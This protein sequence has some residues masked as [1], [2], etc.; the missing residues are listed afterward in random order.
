MWKM[1]PALAEECGLP[2][3]LPA[4]ADGEKPD[5]DAIAAVKDALRCIKDAD[6]TDTACG[7]YLDELEAEREAEKEEMAADRQAAKEKAREVME[8]LK[9]VHYCLRNDVMPFLEEG[10][11]CSEAFSKP[12]D[13]SVGAGSGE[14]EFAVELIETLKWG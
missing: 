10:S 7:Q 6:E 2:T 4:S 12:E 3:V 9:Q 8:Q 13:D 11:T 5:R 14:G 1:C